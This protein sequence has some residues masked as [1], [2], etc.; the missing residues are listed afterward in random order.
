VHPGTQPSRVLL[1]HVAVAVL[2][3]EL[4]QLMEPRLPRTPLQ[5]I[6]SETQRLQLLGLLGIAALTPLLATATLAHHPKTQPSRMLLRHVAV[7]VLLL[8]LL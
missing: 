8:E 6:P 2:F 3:L 7:A 4:L 5:W 1:R